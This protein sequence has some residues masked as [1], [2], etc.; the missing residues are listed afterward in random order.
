MEENK[1]SESDD[2]D[3][4]DELRSEKKAQSSCV[5]CWSKRTLTDM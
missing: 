5:Y 2:S 4:E 1:Q 3:S